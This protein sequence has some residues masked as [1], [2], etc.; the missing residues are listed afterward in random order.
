[1]QIQRKSNQIKGR[2]N[3]DQL[4][5]PEYNLTDRQTS[6]GGGKKKGRSK[7]GRRQIPDWRAVARWR[8]EQTDALDEHGNRALVFKH[9]DGE[10][11]V[12]S[13]FLRISMAI[14]LDECWE[15]L[16][17]HGRYCAR[18]SR[19]DVGRGGGGNN[20]YEHQDHKFSEQ[21]LLPSRTN[22]LR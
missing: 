2:E 13:S 19:E 16:G 22:L 15:L 21:F 6:V 18:D 4:P 5:K 9:G 8:G 17:R 10:S 11:P 12:P 20:A 7:I 3:A 14:M 1:M